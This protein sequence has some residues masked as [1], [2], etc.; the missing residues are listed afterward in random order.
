MRRPGSGAN[1]AFK[2]KIIAKGQRAVLSMKSLFAPEPEQELEV[3]ILP[4]LGLGNL[5]LLSS[6]SKV[7][8]AKKMHEDKSM[9]I[10]EICKT[11]RISRP[12]LYRYLNL[13]KE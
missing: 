8:A 3:W 11:L 6:D 12:T 2:G 10:D 4:Y 7:R 13:A 1:S 5:P 9:E